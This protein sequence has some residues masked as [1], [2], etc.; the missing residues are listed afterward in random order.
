MY[1]LNKNT[2]FLFNEKPNLNKKL[3]KIKP[4]IFLK[5]LSTWLLKAERFI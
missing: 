4:W 1:I 2:Q 3:H 5:N